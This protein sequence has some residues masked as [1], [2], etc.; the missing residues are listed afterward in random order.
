MVKKHG[1][2]Y[3][4]L[5]GKKH[6]GERRTKNFLIKLKEFQLV[7]CFWLKFSL[8][9]VMSYFC[10]FFGDLFSVRALKKILKA[11]SFTEFVLRNSCQSLLYLKNTVLVTMKR[12]IILV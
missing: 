11:S 7:C 3:I 1:I 12:I 6:N 8:G 10:G 2:V 4:Y 5:R 9:K